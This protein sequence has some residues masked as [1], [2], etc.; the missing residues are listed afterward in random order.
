MIIRVVSAPVRATAGF[1]DHVR[2][3]LDLAL[4]RFADRVD[5]VLV[6]IRDDNGV[7]GPKHGPDKR[8]TIHAMVRGASPVM[9]EHRADDFYAVADGAVHKLKRAV[10]HTIDRTRRH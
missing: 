7:R 3:R 10:R 1:V 8:C 4:D 9:V 6:R 2:A 5:R